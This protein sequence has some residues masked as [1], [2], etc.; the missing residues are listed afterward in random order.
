MTRTMSLYLDLV[1]VLS[2]IFVVYG[3]ITQP[4]FSSGSRDMTFLATMSVGVFFAL[5]GFLI[6]HAVSTRPGRRGFAR[7][8]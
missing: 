3:H 2:A 5:S 4:F 8:K 7:Y 6:R 1:R